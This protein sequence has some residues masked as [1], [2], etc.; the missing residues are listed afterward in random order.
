MKKIGRITLINRTNLFIVFI[1]LL[2][3]LFITTGSFQNANAEN[4]AD[5][6]NIIQVSAEEKAFIKSLFLEAENSEP[7]KFIDIKQCKQKE[8]KKLSKYIKKELVM[9]SKKFE[10]EIILIDLNADGKKEILAQIY[11]NSEWCGSHG[12]SMVVL[13]SKNSKYKYLLFT[14]DRQKIILLKTISNGFRDLAF[15]DTFTKNQLTKENIE[16]WRYDGKT[17][18]L[19]AM[20]E[21][22]HNE[23][24]LEDNIIMYK[25]I[26]TGEWLKIKID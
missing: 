23:N 8:G 19:Y 20:K 18:Q 9:P 11:G 26:N 10:A 1:A 22:K 7:L 13:Q 25:F 3:T 6:N 16:I 2:F 21:T 5:N 15:I 12:C 14:N 17:Y 24:V 4:N